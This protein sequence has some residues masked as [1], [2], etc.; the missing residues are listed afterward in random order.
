MGF[1]LTALDIAGLVFATVATAR[2]GWFGKN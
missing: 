2:A 1:L